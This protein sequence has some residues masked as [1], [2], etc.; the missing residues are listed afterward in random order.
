MTDAQAQEWRRIA[1]GEARKAGL[2]NDDLDD[3]E[4]IGWLAADRAYEIAKADE[5][6]KDMDAFAATSIRNAVKNHARNTSR[7]RAELTNHNWDD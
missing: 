4:V 3:A 2:T 7:A 6:I 5:T 1:R